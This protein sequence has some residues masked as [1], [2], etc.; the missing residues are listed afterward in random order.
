[1]LRTEPRDSKVG[2][3]GQKDGEGRVIIKVRYSSWKMYDQGRVNEAAKY[4]AGGE[5][6]EDNNYFSF[7]K[8]SRI[9]GFP[10]RNALIIWIFLREEL[11]DIIGFK[12]T[13]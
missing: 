6:F 1:M 2:I 7:A 8:W 10:T 5:I 13:F 4:I 9:L 11:S 12:M 3:S